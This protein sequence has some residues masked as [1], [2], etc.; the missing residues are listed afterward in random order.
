MDE[1]TT[2]DVMTDTYN[3][4]WVVDEHLKVVDEDGRL[5]CGDEVLSDSFILP[6]YIIDMQPPSGTVSQVIMSYNPNFF[7]HTKFIWIE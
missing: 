5:G 1:D 2:W 3:A 7:D 4:L 6:N